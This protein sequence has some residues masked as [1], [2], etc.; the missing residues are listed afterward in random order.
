MIE[1]SFQP[2]NIRNDG[3]LGHYNLV[4][5]YDDEQQVFTVHD[6]YLLTYAPWGGRIEPDDYDTFIGF[7]YY[8]NKLDQDWR[9]FNFVFIVVYPPEKEN[10]VLNILGP[11]CD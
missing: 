11:L 5:G 9:S 4:V 3:W 1:K 10:E 2:Y 7:D 6:S 8:Y